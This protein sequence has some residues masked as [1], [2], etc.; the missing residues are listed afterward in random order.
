[1]SISDYETIIFDFDG[2]I[3]DT[4]P[5]AIEILNQL[6]PKY[7]Y[8]QARLSIEELRDHETMD[9]IKI[10]DIPL[11]K[12]PFVFHNVQ[13][14]LGE[15]ITTIEPVDG[16]T[17]VLRK[18]SKK[19]LLLGLVTSNLKENIAA[20][21]KSYKITDFDFVYADILP[22]FKQNSLKKMFVEQSVN[23][24]E[25]LYIGDEVRDIRACR[26]VGLPIAGVTWGYDSR[27][28]LEEAEADFIITKPEE[29]LDL[30]FG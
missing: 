10:F 16:I 23:N 21:M 13:T 25:A 8:Q 29:I 6:A 5:K 17:E 22:F 7:G 4:F 14:T 9:L 27:R 1:M 15:T 2:T 26:S 19:H 24:S 28:L 30:V 12:V 3:V 20:Y 11:Y 18:I